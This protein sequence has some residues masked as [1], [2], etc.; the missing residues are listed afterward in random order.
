MPV[1]EGQAVWYEHTTTS[2][3]AV[4]DPYTRAFVAL[5]GDWDRRP[6]R[7]LVKVDNMLQWAW[8]RDVTRSR[9][10]AEFSPALCDKLG[11]DYGWN[12][13]VAYGKWDVTVYEV[14]RME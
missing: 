9:Y 13:G 11:L 7:V 10:V 6:Y 1:A 5:Q 3:D 14:Q 2:A 12:R 4:I 8:R